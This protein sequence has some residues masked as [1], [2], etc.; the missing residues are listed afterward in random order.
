MINMPASNINV[1]ES[2]VSKKPFRLLKKKRKTKQ[3]RKNGY[4]T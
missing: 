4:A 1:N 3:T 2:Q